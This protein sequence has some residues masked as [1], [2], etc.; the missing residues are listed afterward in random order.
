MKPHI[1]HSVDVESKQQKQ[2]ACFCF[3]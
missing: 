3:W 1:R 2:K